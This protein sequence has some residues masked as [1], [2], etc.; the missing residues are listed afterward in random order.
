MLKVMS[1]NLRYGTAKDGENSWEYRK[2]IMIDMLRKSNPDI[3]G[4]QEGLKFQFEYIISK[5]PEYK[6]FGV[7]RRGTDE[8]EFS[9]IIYDS[10]KLK[11]LDGGNFWLSETPDV[12]GSQSWESSL[13]RMVTWALF[14]T[15][16]GN[17]FYHYNTH[18]DHRSELARHRGALLI[19][20][21]VRSHDNDLPVVLTGDFN[22]TNKSFVWDFF[23]GKT[24]YDGER[25]DFVDAW[26][27]AT[28]RKGDAKLTYHGF[29]GERAEQSWEDRTGQ[30]L[31]DRR[32][33]DWI[34]FRGKLSV[35]S[36]AIIS[37]NECGKYPSDHYPVYANLTLS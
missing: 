13:P 25:P 28:V 19:W 12:Q 26:D 35:D 4:S 24:E 36:A 29:K 34:L 8:D 10:H 11:I 22:A 32:M 17:R 23:T 31:I 37:Y 14:Q 33:I 27:V 3:I 15:K 2:N 21:K 7:S 16:T 18:L 6:F 30:T 9:A 5:I 20:E 1:F